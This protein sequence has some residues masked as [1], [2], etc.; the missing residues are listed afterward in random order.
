MTPDDSASRDLQAAV[1]PCV[2]VFRHQLNA[3]HL[4]WE[5]YAFIGACLL[6][7]VVV[8][9]VI[10]TFIARRTFARPRH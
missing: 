10:G 8:G 6:V 9:A 4:T 3:A 7:A 2:R 1:A 5:Q